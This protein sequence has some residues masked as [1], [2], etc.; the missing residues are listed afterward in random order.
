MQPSR[1]GAE[2]DT[3]WHEMTNAYLTHRILCGT[4]D[5]VERDGLAVIYYKG[6]RVAIPLTEMVIAQ[7]DAGGP[8][9]R[10]GPTPGETG[11]QHDGLPG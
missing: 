8:L 1:P 11:Q 4:V 5:G 2:Q 7:S 6:C 10:T 3:L 9:C